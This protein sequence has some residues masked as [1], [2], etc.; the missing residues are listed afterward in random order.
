MRGL[1]WTVTAAK[2]AIEYWK[3]YLL[4]AENID[5]DI[6]SDIHELC[7]KAYLVSKNI[8][9]ATQLLRNSGLSISDS[10][11]SQTIQ[12]VDIEDKLLMRFVKD[13]FRYYKS[14]SKRK[15]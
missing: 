15:W 3:E 4:I 1:K 10:F 8:K 13:K 7:Y 12:N 2:E 11:V 5:I 14:N 6:D 9:D